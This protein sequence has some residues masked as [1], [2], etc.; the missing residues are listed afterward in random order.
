MGTMV[1]YG[2]DP[3]IVLG[4]AWA[5]N[6]A[7]SRSIQAV[8]RDPTPLQKRLDQLGKTLR[9]RLVLVGVIFGVGSCG[10]QCS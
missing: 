3:L 2:R 6:W 9:D 10:A 7:T 4:T 1:T 5:L 8:E